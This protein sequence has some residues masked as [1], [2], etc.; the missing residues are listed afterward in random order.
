MSKALAHVWPRGM[1]PVLGRQIGANWSKRPYFGSALMCPGQMVIS[2]PYMSS[3]SR[4]LCVTLS[5]HFEQAGRRVVLC[6]DMF[7]E[8]LSRGL[9]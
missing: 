7:F 9:R 1:F 6:A 4:S 3:N 2:E 8:G 5:V